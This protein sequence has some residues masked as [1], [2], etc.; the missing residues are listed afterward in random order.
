[1]FRTL[2]T[3]KQLGHE[4]HVFAL[5]PSR[6]RRDVDRLRP[7]CSSLHVH[8]IDTDITLPAA[9]KNFFYPKDLSPFGLNTRASYWVER[10]L[11][12]QALDELLRYAADFGNID[13]VL[14]E[15]LF[16]A[17]YG[18]AVRYHI[19]ALADSTYVLHSHNVEYRIQERL[20]QH[21]ESPLH[22]WYRRHLA[23][24]TK[25]FE[26]AVADRF[27]IVAA[28]SETDAKLYEEMLRSANVRAV[29]PGV[30]LGEPVSHLST[31]SICFLG[32]LDWEPNVEGVLWFVRDV[33]PL[34]LSR[35]PDTKVVIG[36]RNAAQIR[37]RLKDAEAIAF[38]EEV[39][40]AI[41]FRCS[42]GINI[43]P[44]LSGSGVRIKILEALSIACPVVTTV[45]G[46]EGLPFEDRVHLRIADSP[47]DFADACLELMKDPE[48][49]RSMG[50][51]GR[52]MVATTMTWKHSLETMLGH[53]EAI[54]NP[55]LVHPAT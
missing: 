47:Q 49:A 48:S 6:Q 23:R 51:R 26:T 14:C 32:S 44:V 11:S 40:D 21:A 34:I 18:V 22:R 31:S 39:P 3:L 37:H 8:D 38:V 25:A 2:Q 55:P 35:K 29:P 15:T 50:L 45:I 5:N 41:I 24:T 4:V 36:G 12:T 16:T 13:V 30:V 52:D 19:P 53:I 1:M 43:V 27:D 42:H 46:T 33:L 10:F 7:I 54:R 20:A 17:A 28:I 9:L